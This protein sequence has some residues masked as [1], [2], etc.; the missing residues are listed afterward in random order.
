MRPQT[1]EY[2][3]L[4]RGREEILLFVSREGILYGHDRHL[5]CAHIITGEAKGNLK[6]IKYFL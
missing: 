2:G 1:L 6:E 5:L 4:L 3:G